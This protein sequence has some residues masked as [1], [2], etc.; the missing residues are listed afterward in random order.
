M[1]HLHICPCMPSACM[2]SACVP[3]AH[4][5]QKRVINTLELEFKVVVS[6]HMDAT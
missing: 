5:S 1:F 2:P 3:S 6:L 4:G